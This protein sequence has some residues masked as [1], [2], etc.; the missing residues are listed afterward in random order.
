MAQYHAKERARLSNIGK[1]F[2]LIDGQIASLAFSNDLIL[3]TNN[4]TNF[5][6]FADLEDLKVDDWFVELKMRSQKYFQN[7]NDDI[8]YKTRFY[9]DYKNK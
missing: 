8:K 3:V 9:Y 7:K 4:V 2:A 1:N 6:N 5:E